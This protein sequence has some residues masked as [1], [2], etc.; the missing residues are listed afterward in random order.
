MWL[1]R[2]IILENLRRVSRA[3]PCSIIHI[4]LP[5]VKEILKSYSKAPKNQGSIKNIKSIL[6][7][8]FEVKSR[9][10]F[11]SRKAQCCK[12]W[13]RIIGLAAPRQSMKIIFIKCYADEFIQF[14]K[15]KGTLRTLMGNIP[16]EQV[17]IQVVFPRGIAY[18][19]EFDTTDN[20]VCC[21]ES[22]HPFY[23]PKRYKNSSRDN[24]INIGTS[25]F[26]NAILNCHRTFWKHMTKKV[27]FG[28]P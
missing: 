3:S 2:T 9:W 10:H 11:D 8:G 19:M 25:A 23:T 28:T 21:K 6:L 24:F 1:L 4:G 5:Q 22:H 20:R 16:F 13:D 27:D 17:I 26:V 12:C 7:K 18:Q 14:I 15:S